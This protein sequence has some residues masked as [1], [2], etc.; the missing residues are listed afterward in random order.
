MSDAHAAT[1]GAVF[2][3][4]EPSPKK[5]I[6]LLLEDDESI[7][8]MLVAVLRRLGLRVIWTQQG[9]EGIAA[10]QRHEREVAL[11]LA[12][13]RLPDGDGRGVCQQ[14]REIAPTLPVL[15]TSGNFMSHD[16]G[17][18]LPHQLVEYL[19]KP[20]APSEIMARVRHLLAQAGQA[21]AAAAGFV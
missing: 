18:L 17:A 21:E 13:C 9:A 15:V 12:D 8:T 3:V 14:L 4:T 1:Q 5:D 7:A 16:S 6:V 20:Y 2:G 10:F 19:P 11:V